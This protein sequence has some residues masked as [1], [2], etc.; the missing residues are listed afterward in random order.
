MNP[1]V[2]S[3]VDYYKNRRNSMNCY[4]EYYDDEFPGFYKLAEE[5][6]N[7]RAPQKGIIKAALGKI[8]K[9]D[10]LSNNK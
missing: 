8:T 1:N 3:K 9:K 6:K 4:D 7:N 2:S 5:S 10:K